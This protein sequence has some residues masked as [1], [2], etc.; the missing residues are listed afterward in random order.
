MVKRISRV[1]VRCAAKVNLF[2]D[3]RD[4]RADGYHEVITIMCPIDLRDTLIAEARPPEEGFKLTVSGADLPTDQRNIVW[5][6]VEALAEATGTPFSGF[7]RLYKQIPMAAGLGGGSTDAAGAL[8]AFNKLWNLGYKHAQ[9][10]DIAKNIGADVPF[11]LTPGWALARG[12]GDILTPLEARMELWLLLAKPPVAVPTGWAYRAWDSRHRT[13]PRDHQ[14]FLDALE[15]GDLTA[16]AQQLYNAFE[17]V[18]MATH[19]EISYV[20]AQLL[21][22]NPLGVVMTG[23]GPTLVALFPTKQAAESAR[24]QLLE[25]VRRSSE[26]SNLLPQESTP[27]EQLWTAVASVTHRCLVTRLPR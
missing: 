15:S 21:R 14:P 9:L 13:P 20:K 3:I 26:G 16:L 11:F 8:V 4:K 6:A 5:R 24:E 27:G 17:P 22:T 23:S 7:V 19:P 12:I 1:I 25:T 10:G 2:L 18:V